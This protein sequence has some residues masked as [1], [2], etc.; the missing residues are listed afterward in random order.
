MVSSN[1]HSYIHAHVTAA[2]TL[3]DTAHSKGASS[4]YANMRGISVAMD[5][6]SWLLAGKLQSTKAFIVGLKT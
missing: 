5:S 1:N 2:K 4:L 3:V 6:S